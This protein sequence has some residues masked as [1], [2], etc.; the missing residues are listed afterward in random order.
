LIDAIFSKKLD[1]DNIFT[2]YND[3]EEYIIENEDFGMV[4]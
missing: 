1:E 3:G 4:I 2:G